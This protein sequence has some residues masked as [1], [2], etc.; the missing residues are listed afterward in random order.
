MH[1]QL[2]AA[3]QF[4]YREANET[5]SDPSLVGRLALKEKLLQIFRG[6]VLP[7][8]LI[9]LQ[10]LKDSSELRHFRLL[11]S[12]TRSEVIR[13][14]SICSTRVVLWIGIGKACHAQ[15]SLLASS[16]R[17]KATSHLFTKGTS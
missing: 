8:R 2:P 15:V 3:F 6:Y 4:R 10:I 16:L 1:S 14:T 7:S 12:R 17:P 11:F 9:R 5:N 13:P